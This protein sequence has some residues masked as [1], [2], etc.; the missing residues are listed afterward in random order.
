MRFI[1]LISTLS[2][3]TRFWKKRVSGK[4]MSRF[5]RLVGLRAGEGKFFFVALPIIASF[6]LISGSVLEIIDRKTGRNSIYI[7]LSFLTIS[8]IS[9]LWEVYAR[10]KKKRIEGYVSNNEYAELINMLDDYLLDWL[11]C[12]VFRNIEDVDVIHELML[13]I[14]EDKKLHA[15]INA[16]KALGFIG[17]KAI[18]AKDT[19]SKA[20]LVT[21]D[22]VDKLN[23]AAALAII[24]GSNSI[25][26]STLN[27][28]Y[29]ND[30][31][32]KDIESDLIRIYQMIIEEHNLDA[33][34]RIIIDDNQTFESSKLRASLNRSMR[35]FKGKKQN[36]FIIA[37]KFI[38][39]AVVGWAVGYGIELLIEFL[40]NR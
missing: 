28:L 7:G 22:P 20:M 24:E 25:G 37:M 26:L 3:K 10:K 33:T 21:I 30:Q 15:R 35:E 29:N 14:E 38:F 8:I 12:E 40:R 39:V 34:D 9:V 18:I 4:N 32:P 2:H 23:F 11:V 36:W 16:A 13:I 1:Y 19:L 5:E 6:F 27:D 31:L 17:K